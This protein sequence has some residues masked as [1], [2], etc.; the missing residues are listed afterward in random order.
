MTKPIEISDVIGLK[1][2][3]VK[4]LDVVSKGVGVVYEPTK[5][6]RLAQARADEIKIISDA[7]SDNKISGLLNYNSEKLEIDA[8]Y[9]NGEIEELWQ[10][11][12]RF[13]EAKKTLNTNRVIAHAYDKLETEEKVSKDEVDEDWITRFF[14]IAEDVSSEEMQEIWG[15]ILAG[16]IKKPKS[17]SLRTLDFMR[18]ISQ[19]EAELFS[20]VGELAIECHSGTIITGDKKYLENTHNIR[21]N[22]LLFLEELNLISSTVLH[23]ILLKNSNENETVF[24]YADKIIIAKKRPSPERNIEILKFTKLG[25]EVLNF[26]EKKYDDKYIKHFASKIKTTNITIA[27]YDIKSRESGKVVYSKTGMVL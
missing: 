13:K 2:P 17:Y 9:I 20:R 5:I 26:V 15:R 11:S 25:E 12:L 18:N 3:I 1:E 22:D 7:I 23:Y 4:L 16:E 10:E 8:K 24:Y 27:S 19:S 21:L 14:R 6:R